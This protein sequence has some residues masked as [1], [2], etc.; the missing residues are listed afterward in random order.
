MGKAKVSGLS[1]HVPVCDHHGWGIDDLYCDFLHLSKTA[2]PDCRRYCFFA[3]LAVRICI[4]QLAS[5]YSNVAR[6]NFRFLSIV[7]KSV[8]YLTNI[9]L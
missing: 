6:H 4:L 8:K 5:F 2:Q 3:G 7:K 9:L 1:G